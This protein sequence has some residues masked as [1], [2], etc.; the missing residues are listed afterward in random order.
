MKFVLFL[1]IFTFNLH[2][3]AAE[4]NAEILTKSEPTIDAV[5][6]SPDM[7]EIAEQEINFDEQQ[8]L[9]KHQKLKTQI[10]FCAPCHGK[11]GL[12]DVPIYPNLAGQHQE[13][14]FKQLLAFKYRRRKDP[15]MQGMVSRLNEEDMLELAKYYASLSNGITQPKLTGAA[16]ENSN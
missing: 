1:T 11:N 15:I 14:L 13:Y 10:E 5:E 4:T 2:A 8:L 12:S 9:I 3:W 16:N 7:L 6:P